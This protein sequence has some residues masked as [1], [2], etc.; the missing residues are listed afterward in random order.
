M[1]PP[2]EPVRPRI[3]LTLAYFF[4]PESILNADPPAREVTGDVSEEV[5]RRILAARL[6]DTELA[7]IGE[8]ITR[9][10]RNKT[11]EWSSLVAF[12]MAR[13]NNPEH[14]P[15]VSSRSQLCYSAFQKCYR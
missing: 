4:S 11:A 14:S 10:T 7:A 8:E 13:L 3:S 15:L 5:Q 6:S 1:T 9:L 12:D 2:R